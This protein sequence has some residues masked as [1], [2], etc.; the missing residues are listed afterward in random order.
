ML[1]KIFKGLMMKNWLAI[2]TLLM[3]SACESHYR[4]PCQD[5]KNWD[6]VECNNEV[7]RAEGECTSDVLGKTSDQNYFDEYTTQNDCTGE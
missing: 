4:Y 1:G 7:C 5:P 6:K 3:I 2:T